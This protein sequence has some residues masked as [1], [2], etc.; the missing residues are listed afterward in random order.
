M[1][2]RLF[3]VEKHGDGGGAR[4]TGIA[5]GA[6]TAWMFP[7]VWLCVDSTLVIGVRDVSDDPVAITM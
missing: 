4:S 1:A 2:E 6:F 7:L 3:S 5:D